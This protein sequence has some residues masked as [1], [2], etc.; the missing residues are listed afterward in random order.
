MLAY[1]SPVVSYTK[2]VCQLL[3]NV[4]SRLMLEEHLYNQMDTFSKGSAKVS[5]LQTLLHIRRTVGDHPI[6]QNMQ[7]QT[8]A[9][10]TLNK[11]SWQA[12]G[13]LKKPSCDVSVTKKT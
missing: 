11:L 4:L 8:N 2:T 12:T 3:E 5:T 7:T 1:G 13:E 9:I 6:N 10:L